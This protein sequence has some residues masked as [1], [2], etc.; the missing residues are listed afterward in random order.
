MSAIPG[1]GSANRYK[2][3]AVH[4]RNVMRV[5][6]EAVGATMKGAQCIKLAGTLPPL[7]ASWLI[8]CLISHTFMVA[9]SLVSPL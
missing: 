1:T 8:T 2:A 5:V 9:E 7:V 3:P 6:P 4:G